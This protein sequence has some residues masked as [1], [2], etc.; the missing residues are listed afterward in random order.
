MSTS[1]CVNTYTH[2]VTYVADN[3][4]RSMQDI[5]RQSGLSPE[6]LATQWASIDLALRTWISSKYLETVILEVYNPA[7]G[8]L[9]ARWDLD[10]EYGWTSDGD[11]RFWVD[12]DQIRIAIK[13]QGVW[14]SDCLY[15]VIMVTKNGR[16]DVPGWGPCT[17]RS[18]DGFI[19][20]SLGTTVEHSGL[21]ASASF[22]RKK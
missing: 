13:K 1:V 17:L 15:D 11:G 7:T 10:V 5:V 21:G 22:Y 14:P 4:L 3:V 8:R 12:T 6:K 16:P 20:H 2:S 18:T 19:K 9:V